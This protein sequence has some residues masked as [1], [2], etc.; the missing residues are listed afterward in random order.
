MYTDF[1]YHK[2]KVGLSL[3]PDYSVHRYR[4]A[5]KQ[6]TESQYFTKAKQKTYTLYL[7]PLTAEGIAPLQPAHRLTEKDRNGLRLQQEHQQLQWQQQ[8]S[9]ARHRRRWRRHLLSCLKPFHS[10]ISNSTQRNH[11]VKSTQNH[12][13]SYHLNPGPY[14]TRIGVHRHIGA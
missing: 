12:N 5:K 1:S 3:F 6:K 13:K 10:M 9:S 7:R 4:H 8:L 11:S 2:I 14:K